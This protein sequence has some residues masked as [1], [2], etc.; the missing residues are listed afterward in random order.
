MYTA[1]SRTFLRIVDYV[2]IGWAISQRIKIWGF[3]YIKIYIFCPY[4]DWVDGNRFNIKPS[5]MYEY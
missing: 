2:K 4:Q 1:L 5:Q 3:T